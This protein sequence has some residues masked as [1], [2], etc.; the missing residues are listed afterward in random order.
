MPVIIGI[1][2]VGFLFIL[3]VGGRS[4]HPGLQALRSRYYAHRGLHG[5]DAP[6]NSLAAFRAAKD[7]GYGVEL[8]VH[9]MQDGNLA[10][11]HD[12]SLLRTAGAD[13][14][15][16]ELTVSQ[17]MNYHLGDTEEK[18]PL[19][20]QVLAIFHRDA[21]LIIELKSHN[22]NYKALCQAACDL[23]ETYTGS[24]CVESF[25]PR[26]VLWLRKNKP[27]I[28]RGQL[29]EDFCKTGSKL[30]WIIKFAMK[31]QL[32]N[33]LLRPDFVAYRFEHRKSVSNFLCRKVW[34]VQ[35]VSWTIRNQNDFDI[36]VKEGWIP[37]FENFRP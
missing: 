34:G 5:P 29:T 19:L 7:A 23:L 1:T 18:I 11:I 12:S 6:E 36:A 31:Y 37:I 24:Y 3:M 10:V 9:L 26:C 35:G 33:F 21:P 27:D 14:I 25:D 13:V 2:V 15:V 22:N 16:E 17:L 4:G 28:I 32:C 30:P 20:S 8:D